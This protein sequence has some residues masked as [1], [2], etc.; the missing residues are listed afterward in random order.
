MP[1]ASRLGAAGAILLSTL[2]AVASG[3]TFGAADQ[4][5]APVPA[6]RSAWK[7]H[8]VVFSYY[9]L[10]ALYTC[11]GLEDKVRQILLFLGARKD[12]QVQ[13]TGC[14][15]GPSSPSHQ[16]FVTA[17]FDALQAAPDSSD[18]DNVQ[19]HWAAT[20][21][22]PRRPRFMDEG[23]CELVDGMRALLKDGFS[24]RGLDYNASCVPY[25]LSLG[26]FNVRGEVLQPSVIAPAH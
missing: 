19:A 11:D 17:D 25:S 7:H 14:P 2:L 6:E 16:A 15:R 5:V 26:G 13:A 4:P 21:V 22:T 3:R 9:G 1:H 20:Q 10:T 8:H 23:D 24:W 18:A 12:A